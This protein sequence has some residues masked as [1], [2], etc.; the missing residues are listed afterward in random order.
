LQPVRRIVLRWI[1]QEVTARESR[2]E[3]DNDRTDACQI[4]SGVER[5]E[6]LLRKISRREQERVETVPEARENPQRMQLWR[7]HRFRG[8]TD[9]FDE[10]GTGSRK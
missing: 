1:S 9:L 5:H 8:A 2:G 10:T 7:P 4:R 3:H 6:P